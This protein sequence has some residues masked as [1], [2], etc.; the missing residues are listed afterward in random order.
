[1]ATG[2]LEIEAGIEFDRY[3]DR[4]RGA[5]GP[6]SAKLGLAPRLQLEVQ[7]PIVRPAG[8]DTTG[9]GDISIGLKWRFIEAAPP[10]GNLA[11]LASVK[12]PSGS[13][14]SGTGTGTADVNLLFIS[15]HKVG[16][17]NFTDFRRHPARRALPRSSPFLAGR[18]F[19]FANGSCLMPA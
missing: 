13:V 14:D 17:P 7:A 8:E 4:S 19:K 1:M 11:I 6:A 10:V 18:R 9:I 16:S 2:W 3:A 12:A 15:S 5:V